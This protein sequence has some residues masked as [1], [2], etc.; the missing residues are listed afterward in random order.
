MITWTLIMIL[1]GSASDSI[2]TCDVRVVEHGLTEGECRT[3]ASGLSA[4]HTR[5]TVECVL[6]DHDSIE[7][8]EKEV[9]TDQ[10]PDTGK[11]ASEI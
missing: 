2:T 1:C 9:E 5:P 8:D 7:E 11:R 6:E 3:L 10:D 4:H